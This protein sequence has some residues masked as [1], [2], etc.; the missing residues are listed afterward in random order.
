MTRVQEDA[1]TNRED[2]AAIRDSIKE[3]E[4]GQERADF[5]GQKID[6]MFSMLS[7]LPQ[8]K[9]VGEFPPRSGTESILE[10]DGILPRSEGIRMSDE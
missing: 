10:R 3:L 8:F 2:V 4:Q 9:L 6:S 7:T 1:T 5:C